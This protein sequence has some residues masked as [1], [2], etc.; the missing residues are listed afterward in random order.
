MAASAVSSNFN[1]DSGVGFS[2]SWNNLD[3]ATAAAYAEEVL[4]M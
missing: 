2:R 1:C 4:C 3:D